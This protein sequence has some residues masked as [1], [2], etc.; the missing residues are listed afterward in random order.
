MLKV[1]RYY[2][3]ANT[4]YKTAHIHR[5]RKPVLVWLLSVLLE[6]HPHW[7]WLGRLSKGWGNPLCSAY[8]FGWTRVEQHLRKRGVIDDHFYNVKYDDLAPDDKADF[9]RMAAEHLNF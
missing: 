6:K 4:I 9:E 2:V 8:C 3:G 7:R 5:E 1:T